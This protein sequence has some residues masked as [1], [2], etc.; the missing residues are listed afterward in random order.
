M[1]GPALR[2]EQRVAPNLTLGVQL[3]HLGFLAVGQAGW[4]G[5]AGHE[6]RRQVAETERRH[7]QPRHD[8]VAHAEEQ[9]AVEHVVRQGDGG[10]ER[11]HVARE[12][13]QLHAGL[14]LSD[15]V[16]HRRHAASEL[17][18]AARLPHRLLD[19]RREALERLMRGEHV[20]VRRDDR[21][22]DLGI[23]LQG[24]LVVQI[25]GGEAVREVAAGQRAPLGPA[26]G[27][28]V[29]VIEI[30]SARRR[31]CAGR[32]VRSPLRIRGFM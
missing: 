16:A 11:D 1:V 17:R 9:R 12:Q 22:V 15:A 21:D 31:R 3:A 19:Q 32:S 14:A 5:S 20:V 18:D 8:L 27:S 24:G 30:G 13:R 10:G 4:H 7:D 28:R 23:A 6:D 25:A 2:L 29:D 26:L